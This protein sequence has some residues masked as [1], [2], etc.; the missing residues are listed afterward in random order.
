MTEQHLYRVALEGGPIERLSREPGLARGRMST[1]KATQVYV[2]A[3]SPTT[4]NRRGCA[5]GGAT[6][7]ASLGELPSAAQLPNPEDF[8]PQRSSCASTPPEVTHST[9][10]WQSAQTARRRDALPLIVY[11][12]GGPSGQQVQRAVARRA[13]LV[14]GLAHRPRFRGR[15]DRRARRGR[16]RPRLRPGHLRRAARQVRSGRPSGRR[17]RAHGKQFPE[18][19]P[20]TASASRL[21]V[22]R[23]HDAHGGARAAGRFRPGWPAAPVTDWD[24]L[25]HPLHRA[26]PRAAEHGPGRATIRV[27]C[28][29]G[30]R[31]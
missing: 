11:V 6:G 19:G 29:A 25:R 9:C 27:R 12:Y 16:A 15:A 24:G 13:R 21:V 3:R 17:A 23:L 2:D 28:C 10:V 20:R 14:R 7:R 31:A 26:L 30:P 8:R 4:G 1:A 5:R 22:R 18:T